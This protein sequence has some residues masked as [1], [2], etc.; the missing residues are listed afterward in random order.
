MAVTDQQKLDLLLKKIGFTKTKTGNVVGTGNPG[1][2]TP[3]EPFAEAIPSPLVIPNAS[4]WN[5][6]DS[7]TATPPG[8]DTNQIKVYSTSSA[9]RLTLDTTSSGD[10]AWIAYSTYN[11]TSSTRLTNWIDT[12]FGA[13]YLIK[14][15]NTSR[16]IKKPI[17]ISSTSR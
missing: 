1:D 9:L 7:I 16:V 8:A 12:Q 6:A 14:V 15:K 17:I 10:R 2:G 5:E 11:D 3:K 4:L 13:L